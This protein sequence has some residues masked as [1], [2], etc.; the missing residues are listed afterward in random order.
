[1]YAKL[2]VN[3]EAV[4]QAMADDPEWAVCVLCSLS[5]R[6]RQA[7]RESHAA[8]CHSYDGALIDLKRTTG[9]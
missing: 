3:S 8:Q 5:P 7:I 2:F 6:A 9:N 4:A 1:M